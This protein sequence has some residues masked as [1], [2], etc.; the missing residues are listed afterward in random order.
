M[1]IKIIAV[2][3]VAVIL[4]SACAF[5]VNG[6]TGFP[7]PSV[8]QQDDGAVEDCDAEDWINREDDCGFTKPSPPRKTTAA[9][10]TPG[11]RTTRR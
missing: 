8:T 11:P 10:V 6:V 9:K 3:I 1:K 5:A 2:A 4:V 7:Q